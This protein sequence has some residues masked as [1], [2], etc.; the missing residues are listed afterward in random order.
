MNSTKKFWMR[1]VATLGI[2]LLGSLNVFAASP[3][4]EGEPVTHNVRAWVGA[5]IIDGTGKPAIEN[6]TLL[7]RDGRIVAVGT[8]VKL[9]AGAEKIDATGKTII[10]GLINAHGHVNDVSQLGV[11]LRD[12]IT[13]VFSLGGDKEFA[14][15]E[16]SATAPPGTVPHLYI[17]GPI[18]DSTAIPGAVAV[19]TP[20][21]ARKSVEELIRNKP[22]IV[23][24]RVDDFLGARPKMSP[25]TY[26]AAIDEAHKNGFRTAAHVVLLDDAKGVLRAGVDYI[27]HSVRDREVDEEFIAL[28]KKRH[29]FYSPTLTREFAVFGYSETPSFFSDPFFLKEADPAEIAKMEDPKRQESVAKDPGALWYKEHLP[30][31]MRNLKKLSDA[32]IVIAMGTDS[33]G[34]PGRFQ[35]YFEHLELEYETKAGV[36]PMQALISATSGAAKAVN[37]SQEAGTLEKGKWADFVVLSANPL[38]DIRNTRAIDSVWIGGVRVPAKKQ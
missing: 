18:Q 34:G 14:L 1:S 26:E 16:Q 12:G 36:T 35:G 10:P 21:E 7:I 2:F 33:G 3:E 15:R 32:G 22:D 20:E 27:A 25:E 24:V 23:K 30:I 37:I 38:D 4:Q 29:A 8:R 9:P 19:K 13:T 11:Y 6:A 31:A 17:A 28:M 5:R